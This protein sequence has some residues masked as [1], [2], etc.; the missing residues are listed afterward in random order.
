LEYLG[1]S[2]V[3]KP[4][5]TVAKLNS[6]Q[7]ITIKS[8]KARTAGLLFRVLCAPKIHKHCT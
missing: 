1:K 8:K 6:G 2:A 3:W 5:A 4:Q 7:H